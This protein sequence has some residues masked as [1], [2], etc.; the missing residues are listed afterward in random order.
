MNDAEDSFY[1][2]EAAPDQVKEIFEWDAE[3]VRTA[4]ENAGTGCTVEEAD[5]MERRTLSDEDINRWFS[6]NSNYGKT[7]CTL[8]GENDFN[9]AV[10][11]IRMLSKNRSF[12]WKQTHVIFDISLKK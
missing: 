10:S 7:I 2:G 9:E 4:F 5:F 6:T 1:S 12:Q 11:I 8:M 3:Y